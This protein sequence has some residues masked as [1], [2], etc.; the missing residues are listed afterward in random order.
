MRTRPL[1]AA[2][3][4]CAL[5]LAACAD[6]DDDDAGAGTSAPA[7]TA[8]SSAPATG[9]SAPAGEGQEVVIGAVL[10]PTSLD[11]VTVDGAA[12]DQ[13]LLD[14]IYETLLVYTDEGEI[15]PGLAALPEI[16]D[17]G[18]VYTFTLQD[19]VTFHSGEPMTSADVVWSLDAQ[20][21][22]GA[23]E[24]ERLAGITSVEAPDESTVVVTLAAP[25]ND[26]P[27]GMTRRAGAVLQADATGLENS[28]NGTGPFT[29]VEWNVGASIT[30][31]RNDAYWGEA[32]SVSGVTF[33]YFPDPNAAVNAFTTGDVQILTGVNT[34]LV[35]P[36][37]DNPDYVVNEGT[38]NGEFTLGMNNGRE[39]FSN[40]EV[41]KAVRQAIDKEGYKELN[42]GFGTLIG[43]PVPPTDPWYEDLTGVVPYDPDAASA[44]LEA[45][46]YGDGL[47]VTLLWPNF[48]PITNA[49]YVASQLSEVG[50]NV[51]IEPVEFAVW[52]EQA[53]TNKNYDMTAVLH[54]EARDISNYA[55]P[56]YYWG[57]DNP[58]VQQLI[59]DAKVT[60]D[61]DEA[62]E[63]LK[64]AARQIAEDSPVDWLILA[65]D[66]IVSTPDIGGYPT[67]DTASRFDASGIT[68]TG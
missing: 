35:G 67:N 58:D 12:L 55:N 31:A 45:A 61:P 22:E 68:I 60:T 65:T 64:Q 2:S 37:Q 10:E 14:N 24:S 57:Y 36:L 63:L 53:F 59:G 28:A 48:Y 27:F 13:I 51:T 42:N 4:A 3:V 23:N 46:G 30:L 40:P 16:S 1:L 5:V 6:D 26:F 54:V 32:P 25:D 19:G 52:L 29:F 38:T 34:D 17:D 21:A 56:D 62:V 8:P 50:I 43:G 66:L 41:R 49:E 47:D 15:E 11:I 39:P 7:A 44:A 9:G 33:L 20:R 18:T